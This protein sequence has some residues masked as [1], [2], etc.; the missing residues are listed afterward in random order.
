MRTSFYNK[1]SLYII[2]R[3]LFFR[4]IGGR[5][6][7][8][9][10][11]SVFPADS[12]FAMP[13]EWSPH[14]ACWMGWPCRRESFG[15]CK[16]AR[17]SFSAVAR[18]ISEFEPV[19][20]IVR[21]EDASDARTMLGESA[22]VLELPLDDSWL[23]D[24]GPTFV[25]NAANEIA[26]IN[27]RFNA[28]GEKYAPFDKDN[29]I[30]ERVLR[31]VGAHCF[32]APLIMEG[33]ALHSD[34]EGTILTTEQCLLHPNRNPS[35]SREEI[36]SALQN[37]LGAQ[38]VIWLSGDSRDDETDGHVDNVACFAAPGVA[39]A[40]AG[41]DPILAENIRRLREAEDAKGRKIR[42]VVLPRPEVREHGED[43]LA[44]YINFYF[45]NG[46]LIMPSFGVA[47][48]ESARAILAEVFSARRIVQVAARAIV[49]GGGGIHCITQQQPAGNPRAV[50]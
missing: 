12:G 17:E 25:R 32:N 23:R 5:A 41:D 28:W 14:A 30:A 9:C 27:W 16:D 43:L 15:D 2:P 19:R 6:Y 20:M 18:A 11:M 40:M 1:T 45:V 10:G 24:I 31:N 21:P 13:A 37:F 29:A 42:V 8:N 44:S 3:F 49:R 4:N 34:G 22:E 26:G 50:V 35:L 36:E 46:G 48:D 47:E 33:G 7:Y 38:K 39:L